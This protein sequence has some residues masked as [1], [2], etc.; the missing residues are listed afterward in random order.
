MPWLIIVDCRLVRVL[1][2]H[3]VLAAAGGGDAPARLAV[4]H[5]AIQTALPG[6]LRY[7]WLVLFLLHA[8]IKRLIPEATIDITCLWVLDQAV[9]FGVGDRF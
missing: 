2:G 3:G 5:A 1:A 8:V 4:N 9:K 7:E 6:Q